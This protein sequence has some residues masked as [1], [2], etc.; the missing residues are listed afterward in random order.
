MIKKRRIENTIILTT[1]SSSTG[2]PAAYLPEKGAIYQPKDPHPPGVASN[3]CTRLCL[4]CAK[5]LVPPV[6]RWSSSV[7]AICNEPMDSVHALNVSSN[8]EIFP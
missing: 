7:I 4:G 1:I 6:S 3:L 5:R 8:E 2:L